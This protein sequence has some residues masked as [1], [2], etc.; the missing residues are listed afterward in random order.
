MLN[1]DILA[2]GTSAGG[3]EALR[4]LAKGFP[5]DFRASVLVTIHLSS[6]FGSSLDNILT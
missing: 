4:F 5:P 2:I 1:R 6:R 3:V